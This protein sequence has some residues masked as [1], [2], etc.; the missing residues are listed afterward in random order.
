M[1]RPVAAR[2]ILAMTTPTVTELPKPLEPVTPPTF[3]FL[4]V[5]D[6]QPRPSTPSRRIVD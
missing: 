6:D 3:V 4:A 1:A 5:R 2:T